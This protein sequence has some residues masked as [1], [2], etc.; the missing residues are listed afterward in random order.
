MGIIKGKK[1][2]FEI[3]VGGKRVKVGEGK[4]P[5][6]AKGKRSEELQEIEEASGK[7]SRAERWVSWEAAEIGKEGIIRKRGG[8]RADG[9]GTEL[10]PENWGETVHAS[11]DQ[12]SQQ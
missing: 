1:W 4:Y 3:S 8:K 6:L 5:F 11:S 7:A 9:W 2:S 10:Y 12:R